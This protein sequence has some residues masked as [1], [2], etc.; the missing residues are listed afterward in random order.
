MID[1]LIT[2]T[3]ELSLVVCIQGLGGNVNV[4]VLDRKDMFESVR[5]VCK[6]M[7]I[8]LREEVGQCYGI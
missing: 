7:C 3:C 6:E 4:C 1:C 8:G 5:H 2:E